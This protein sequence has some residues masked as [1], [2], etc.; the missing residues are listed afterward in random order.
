MFSSVLLSCSFIVEP[1]SVLVMSIVSTGT[2]H[3]NCNISNLYFAQCIFCRE[4]EIT[5]EPEICVAVKFSHII[6]C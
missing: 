1:C 5:F 3:V 4:Y 2:R 6:I